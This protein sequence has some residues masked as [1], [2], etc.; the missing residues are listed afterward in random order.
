MNTE[1]GA[2]DALKRAV[3]LVENLQTRVNKLE[4]ENAQL[5]QNLHEMGFNNEARL[6]RIDVLG[7]DNAILRRGIRRGFW[8][9]NGGESH[10]PDLF[11]GYVVME[12]AMF[13]KEF[14][15]RID[16]RELK[17]LALAARNRANTLK[18]LRDSREAL[19]DI[20]TGLARSIQAPA[21]D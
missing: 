11:L 14:C 7:T 2:M 3:E 21:D 20:A 13:R 8:M 16:L 12:P 10:P 9:W 5:R 1:K 6:N 17:A 15:K 19:L 18:T 4:T